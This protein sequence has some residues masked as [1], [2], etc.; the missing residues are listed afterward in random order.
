MTR[1]LPIILALVVCVSATAA[2]AGQRRGGASRGGGSGRVGGSSRAGGSG[3][4]RVGPSAPARPRE[5]GNTV[6]RAVPRAGGSYPRVGGSYRGYS[7]R[8]SYPYYGRAYPYLGFGLG[9]SYG[10]YG[11]GWPLGY[12]YGYGYDGYPYA[13][14]YPDYWPYGYTVGVPR[15]LGQRRQRRLRIQGAPADA[16][17]FVDGNYVGVVRDLRR[18]QSGGGSAPDRDSRP[19]ST[20]DSVQ[21]EHPARTDADVPRRTSLSDHVKGLV[22]RW[23]WPAPPYPTRPEDAAPRFA[24]SR[25]ALPVQWRLETPH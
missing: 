21:R 13:Y 17:V 18:R 19:G 10:Y 25:S 23:A 4:G 20:A 8:Y 2:D 16:Q 22:G 11:P 5:P 15:R 24:V 12:G 3:A 9:Y 7:Y 6:G 1:S 14:P